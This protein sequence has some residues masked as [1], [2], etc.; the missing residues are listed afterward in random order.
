MPPRTEADACVRKGWGPNEPH[1]HLPLLQ[2]K[3]NNPPKNRL[4]IS[5]RTPALVR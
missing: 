2:H 4:I 5:K 1:A 3:Q